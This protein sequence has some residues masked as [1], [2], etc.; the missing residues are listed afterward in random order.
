MARVFSG[1]QPTGRKHLGNLVGAIRHWVADQD[2]PGCVYCIVDLHS[3]TVPRDP[4]ELRSSTLDTAALLLA[5]GIDPERSTF[6]VQSHV[7]EHAQLAWLLNC[8]ATMGELGRMVQFKEK[9][10]GQESVLVGLFDYPV[11]QAAD[12]LLYGARRVPVGEDQR[13]HLELMRD[14]AMRFNGRFGETFVVPEASIPPVGARVVDLQAPERKMSTTGTS[15]AGTLYVLDPPATLRKKI[16][17]AVTDSEASVRAD[18]SKPGVTGLLDLLGAVTDTPVPALEERYAGAG[19]G[20]LKKDVA[21][22]VIAALEPIQ[23]RHAELIADVGELQRILR[24][25]AEQA[26]AQ[27]APTLER[28]RAAMGFVAPG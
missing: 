6:F 7:A 19:Y 20:A 21:E 11:L 18:P 15:D 12:V 16:M 9:S 17:S 14:V 28:A 5:A 23:R 1:I 2:E 25:G 26:R 13:Q 10:K 22:A 3:I 24:L 27:A 8:V 4:D